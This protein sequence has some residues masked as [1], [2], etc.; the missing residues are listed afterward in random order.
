MI[1]ILAKESTVSRFEQSSVSG[2]LDENVC[3]IKHADVSA[4]WSQY[5]LLTSDRHWDN[6]KSDL[7]LQKKHL[8]WAKEV[9]AGIIDIGDFFCVM[10]GKYDPRRDRESVR[11]EHNVNDYLDAVITTAIDWFEP[12][13]DRFVLVGQGNHETNFI[14]RHDTDL[15]KRFVDGLNTKSGASV[16]KGQYG[17]FVRFSFARANNGGRNQ[18]ID[19]YYHHGHGG[20][21]PVTKGVIQSNRRAASVDADIIISGHI[22]ESWALTNMRFGLNHNGD[23]VRQN[24]QLHICL[25][26]YK[27]EFGNGGSGWH[28]EGGRPPK[29]VGAWVLRFYLNAVSNQIEYDAIPFK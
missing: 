20:G 14:K 28:V 12:Y 10:Q 19:L 15:N 11:P 6:P 26:T 9:G 1:E 27:E 17:G 7:E 2:G 4:G 25:R 22:H 23:R 29:P 24:E 21:G 18:S 13:A 8:N 5:Y 3:R 16:R